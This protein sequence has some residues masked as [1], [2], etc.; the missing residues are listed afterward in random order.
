MPIPARLRGFYPIDWPELSRVIRFGRAAGACEQCGRPNGARVF[1]L[2]DGRW[3]DA[4][5]GHWRD[6][7]GRRVTVA[8]A[9]ASARSAPRGSTSP[10]PT[11]TTTRRTTLPPTSPPGASG[12]TSCTTRPNIS[13]GADSLSSAGGRWGICSSG[14]IHPERIEA[15]IAGL[16]HRLAPRRLGCASA[17]RIRRGVTA[18]RVGERLQP[19]C[20]VRRQGRI[21]GG[22]SAH[23]AIIA[24]ECIGKAPL[25][26][27]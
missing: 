17:P 19:R 10:P 22:P 11:G 9:E 14:A 23:E 3:F 24:S 27:A 20:H 5:R 13:A 12:A 2:G 6:G 8:I 7:S 18:V 25:R 1:H 4:R 16:R 26:P 21:A 15:A